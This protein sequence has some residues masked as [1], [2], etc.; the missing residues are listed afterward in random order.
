MN[1]LSRNG[2]P[3]GKYQR[4]MLNTYLCTAFFDHQ[5][6]QAHMAIL[7]HIGNGRASCSA[8]DEEKTEKVH[9]FSSNDTSSQSGS[10]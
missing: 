7:V 8:K 1:A 5:R 10:S 9:T 4:D 3:S 6:T 2:N